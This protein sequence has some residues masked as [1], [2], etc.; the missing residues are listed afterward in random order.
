MELKAI[1]PQAKAEV[2]PLRPQSYYKESRNPIKIFQNKEC[3]TRMV[4][5]SPQGDIANVQRKLVPTKDE[6]TKEG[7]KQAKNNRIRFVVAEINSNFVKSKEHEQRT[8]ILEPIS[9]GIDGAMHERDRG[10]GEKPGAF[11]RGC[12][13]SVRD[14]QKNKGGLSKREVADIAEAYSKER[15]AWVPLANQAQLGE[16]FPSGMENEVYY[17]ECD[18][19]VYKVNNLSLN[20]SSILSLLERVKDHNRLFPNTAYE[21]VGFSGFGNG[22]VYPVLKQGHIAYATFATYE[23]IDSYMCSLDFEPTGK[24]AEYTN[25][26]YIVFDL[27][28]RNV[29]KSEEGNIYVI[30]AVVTKR[31]EK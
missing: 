17:N 15:G 10:V 6:L 25:G 13:A 29:L 4:T 26:E 24:D 2:S 27:H 19:A 31:F 11:Q 21:L 12:E 7:K 3:K 5:G 1:T 14:A 20:E 16:P 8:E 28:P 30:D 9:Q 22:S 23:E 18:S